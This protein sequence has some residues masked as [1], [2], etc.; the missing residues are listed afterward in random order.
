M[1]TRRREDYR[2]PKAGLPLNAGGPKVL[3]LTAAKSRIEG[4]I[5]HDRSDPGLKGTWKTHERFARLQE[6]KG[7]D[8]CRRIEQEKIARGAEQSRRRTEV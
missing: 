6:L 4:L 2:R 7:N 5:G 8:N 1:M 3:Q